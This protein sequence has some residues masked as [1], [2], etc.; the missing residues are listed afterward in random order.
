MP[1]SRCCSCCDANRAELESL[2]AQVREL[3]AARQPIVLGSGALVIA[4]DFD[5][6]TVGQ[7]PHP[8]CASQRTILRMLIE[9]GGGCVDQR[10]ARSRVRSTATRFYLPYVFRRHP[11]R[12]FIVMCSSYGRFRL[13][14]GR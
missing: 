5:E 2:R 14:I 13:N 12:P 8:L 1:N 11:L 9:A 3:L 7:V 10:E 4:P 6:V